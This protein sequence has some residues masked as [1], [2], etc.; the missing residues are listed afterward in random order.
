MINHGC[1]EKCKL[2]NFSSVVSHSSAPAALLKVTQVT[3]S[4]INHKAM[5]LPAVL[6]EA[7]QFLWRQA[8]TITPIPGSDLQVGDR[9][10][11]SSDSQEAAEREEERL[12]LSPKEVGKGV[13]IC[14]VMVCAEPPSSRTRGVTACVCV[15]I[16]VPRDV[17]E[18]EMYEISGKPTT[19]SCTNT[20]SRFTSDGTEERMPVDQGRLVFTGGGI[21][22]IKL[23]VLHF[24]G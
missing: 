4:K 2:K 10:P 21:M 14:L 15:W 17:A 7:V 8:A 12:E 22:V 20:S 1:C 18:S 5:I 24:T 9:G 3:F 6:P 19:Q 11:E 16:Q 13:L 23:F